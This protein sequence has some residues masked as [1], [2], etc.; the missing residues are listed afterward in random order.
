MNVDILCH[1]GCVVPQVTCLIGCVAL[2]VVLLVVV[3]LLSLL[4]E[5]YCRQDELLLSRESDTN[6][7]HP[8]RQN[9]HTYTLSVLMMGEVESD[10]IA[11]K[12]RKIAY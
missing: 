8:G 6:G 12:H 10:L 1:R 3:V 4:G 9:T 7:L 11:I 5:I 2:C